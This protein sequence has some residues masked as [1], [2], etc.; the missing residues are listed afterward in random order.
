[1][2]LTP[3]GRVKVVDFGIASV[4]GATKGITRTGMILGTP[5]YMA[6]E[7]INGS[8]ADARSDVFALGVLLYEM[9]SGRPP[10]GDTASWTVI[11]AVLERDPTPLGQVVDGVPAALEQ[12]VANCLAKAPAARYPNAAAVVFALEPVLAELGVRAR[13]GPAVVEPGPVVPPVGSPGARWWLQFH[14]AVAAVSLALMMIPAWKLMSRLPLLPG[15]LLVLVLLVMAAGIGTMRLHLWFTARHDGERLPEEVSR[16]VPALRWS[17]RVFALLLGL[18]GAA[19]A[20]ASPELAGVC[21]ACAAGTLVAGEVIEPAT[22]ARAV[23]RT[24]G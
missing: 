12:V 3:A 10:F 2:M 7:Q 5:G 17:N 24:G 21:V 14:Q 23:G 16:V 18:G 19:V 9:V 4:D 22:I 6:P 8:G 1:V 11:A 20:D 13:T 15:R